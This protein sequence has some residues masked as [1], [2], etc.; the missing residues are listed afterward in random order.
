MGIS[1]FPWQKG[2]SRTADINTTNKIENEISRFSHFCVF[3]G[4]ALY[5]IYL[6]LQYWSL[7][8]SFTH[9]YCS[10]TGKAWALTLNK[11]FLGYQQHSPPQTDRLPPFSSR[12]TAPKDPLNSPISAHPTHTET[13]NKVTPVPYDNI[14]GAG[15]FNDDHHLNSSHRPQQPRISPAVLTNGIPSPL[16]SAA[17]TTTAGVAVAPGHV[18]T[19]TTVAAA[20]TLS[21]YTTKQTSPILDSSANNSHSNRSPIVHENNIPQRRTNAE[22]LHSSPPLKILPASVRLYHRDE[23]CFDETNVTRN[24]LYN[25]DSLHSYAPNYYAEQHHLSSMPYF[26][27]CPTANEFSSPPGEWIQSYSFLSFFHFFT[28]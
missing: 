27:S 22:S 23:N 17:T 11:S 12:S 1:I 6:L 14:S 28:L 2:L 13:R 25:L 9:L 24:D 5:E 21:V 3:R 10:P 7:R 20:A 26:N 15:N 16:D 4:F 19:T 18:P 8:I